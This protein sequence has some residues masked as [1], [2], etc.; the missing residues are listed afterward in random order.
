MQLARC[1]DVKAVL[2]RRFEG[3]LIRF[4]AA[5]SV[6]YP[7]GGDIRGVTLDS[8]LLLTFQIQLCDA[9]PLMEASNRIQH[10]LYIICSLV[11]MSQRVWL[12]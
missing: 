1:I 7:N 8:I 9:Y 2:A 10:Y 6:K 5:E 4:E 12:V 11:L 3:M